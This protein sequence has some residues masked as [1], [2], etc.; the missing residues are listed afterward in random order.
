MR[1]L[2]LFVHYY[3]PQGQFGGK[4]KYQDADIRRSCVERSLFS[5][6]ALRDLDVKI[7]GHHGRALVPLNIDLSD[8]SPNPQFLVYEALRL[9]HDY[10]HDYDRFLVVEDD[11]LLSA[12]QFYNSELFNIQFGKVSSSRWILHP[13][14][15][16][17][18]SGKKPY[19]IDLEVVRRRKKD[20]LLFDGRL[21]QEHE[22]PHSGLLNVTSDQLEIIR[23]E[24]DPR[25]RGAV[26]G[27]PM[28][29]AFAHYHKPFRLFRLIDGLDRHTIQHLDPMAWNQASLAE[30][31]VRKL[32][33]CLGKNQK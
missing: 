13:N 8:V 29:S 22:N 2:C 27:G 31:V 21:V 17:Y 11:L 1:S 20:P 15:I 26:I 18:R 12:D 32:R 6:K 10:R 24:V 28:A 9:L 4:S 30:R 14:R 16:E 23:Q 5:L 19:C 25:F 3:N 7:C 33:S